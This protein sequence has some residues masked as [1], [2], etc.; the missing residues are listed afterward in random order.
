M[1]D[2]SKPP[3]TGNVVNL[4]KARKQKARAQKEERAAQ[5][6]L[7]F[8]QSKA[9]REI[10]SAQTKNADRKLDRHLLDK[11]DDSS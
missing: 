6:R 9:E 7:K 8:G 2:N 1:S 11:D 4:N 10:T 3:S 5:N